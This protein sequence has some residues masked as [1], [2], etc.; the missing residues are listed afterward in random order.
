M[1]KSGRE[2]FPLGQRSPFFLSPG[3][4]KDKNSRFVVD[5]EEPSGYRCSHVTRV[6]TQF[7]NKAVELPLDGFFVFWGLALFPQWKVLLRR[8]DGSLKRGHHASPLRQRRR[9]AS[10]VCPKSGSPGGGARMREKVTGVEGR[11][12]Q[13]YMKKTPDDHAG[14][15]MAGGS[16]GWVKSAIKSEKNKNFSEIFLFSIT[17]LYSWRKW[18]LLAKNG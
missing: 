6:R 1:A 3:P 15:I 2:Y 16:S 8:V 7:C 14:G 4:K 18:R 17:T 5:N 13:P 11:R 10:G 12:T 9:E